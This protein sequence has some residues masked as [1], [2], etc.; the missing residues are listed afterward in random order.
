MQQRLQPCPSP[1]NRHTSVWLLALGLQTA[2]C[3]NENNAGTLTNTNVTGG[4]TSTS[5]IS[6]TLASNS[7]SIGTSAQPSGSTT[8]ATSVAPGDEAYTTSTSASS[9][10]STSTSTS[11]DSETVATD[12]VASSNA[13]DD[14]SSDVQVSA[15]SGATSTTEPTAP[16]DQKAYAVG[17]H[18][19]YL[20]DE[21]TDD[22]PADDVCAHERAHEISFTF[23]GDPTRIYDVKLR[24]RGL[25]EPTNVSGGETP[26]ATH[27][28]FKV[29]GN[30]EKPDYSQWQI[31]VG[32]PAATYYLN[33]YPEVGHTIYKEDFEATIQVRGA[34]EVRVRVEDANDRQIDNGY[35]GNPD[36]Q[37]LLEGVTDEVVDGQVLRLDVLDV[38]TAQ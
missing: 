36:R 37:Q 3:S 18:E 6:S 24:I 35:V 11:S 1:F 2:G 9:S 8:S 28:Y 26:D 33:H 32:E 22:N 12:D 31:V 23:G 7:T 29:N 14:R 5:V 17:F 20:H 19:L 10:N 38:T 34:A 16:D 30:V 4:A 15:E 13:N 27:P 25:F 21:C